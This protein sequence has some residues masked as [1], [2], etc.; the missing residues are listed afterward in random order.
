MSDVYKF[1]AT[2]IKEAD[3]GGAYVQIPF[4]VKA[5][6]GKSRV[7]VSATFDGEAYDGQVVKMGTPCHIIGIRKDIQAKI[8]KQP[9]DSVHVTLRE[10]A[11]TPQ[12]ITTVDAYIDQFDGE[13][14]ERLENLRAVIL[15]C[16]PDITEKIS[17]G[18][19]TFVLAGNLVHIAAEKRHIGFHPAPSAIAAFEP[20]F[21]GRKFSKGTLQLPHDRPIPY[22]LVRDMTAFRVKEQERKK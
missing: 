13:L 11:K 22:D 9:G 12:T 5:A 17:W 19:I 6:F 1:D 14:R 10:R 2:I 21:E 4:D 15:A 16:S 3:H 8:G 7:S 18:M 20:R